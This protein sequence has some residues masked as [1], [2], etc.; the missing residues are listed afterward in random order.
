[1]EGMIRLTPDEVSWIWRRRY[2][3]HCTRHTDR[4]PSPRCRYSKRSS[5]LM[6][7]PTPPL[8]I[9]WRS[10]PIRPYLYH[11]W[12]PLRKSL[13]WNWSVLMVSMKD[14]K[15]P[16]T[17]TSLHWIANAMAFIWFYYVC[18]VFI[19]FIFQVGKAYAGQKSPGKGS[20]SPSTP[21]NAIIWSFPPKSKVSCAPPDITVGHNGINKDAPAGLVTSDGRPD[22]SHDLPR[23]PAIASDGSAASAAA[24]SAAAAAMASGLGGDFCCPSFGVRPTRLVTSANGDPA[25]V[26]CSFLWILKSNWIQKRQRKRIVTGKRSKT[27]KPSNQSELAVKEGEPFTWNS[28]HERL[29]ILL[30]LYIP[31]TRRG[32]SSTTE[33]INLRM[34]GAYTLLAR[35]WQIEVVHFYLQQPWSFDVIELMQSRFMMAK[36]RPWYF[37]SFLPRN[38]ADNSEN[39]NAGQIQLTKKQ[40]NLP[41]MIVNSSIKDFVWWWSCQARWVMSFSRSFLTHHLVSSRLCNASLLRRERI[42]YHVVAYSFLKL[43]YTNKED[44]NIN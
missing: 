24:V 42:S 10:P 30:R 18:F 11:R 35:R 16:T 33:W 37:Y 40:N 26:T 27:N 4:L 25:S 17:T 41:R 9:T 2:R 29:L 39:V 32:P 20:K 36:S 1:M 28:I 38:K 31:S 21:P 14:W 22:G 13:I 6:P 8:A 3:R 44:E 34:M 23:D 5:K 19:F 7:L 15:S 12:K 43:F